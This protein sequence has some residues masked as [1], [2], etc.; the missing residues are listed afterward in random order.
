MRQ[1]GF[2]GIVVGLLAMS[3]V[4]QEAVTIKVGKPAASDRVK[5]TKNEKMN[6]KVNF[7]V[8]GK[9]ETKEDTESKVIVYTDEII[10]ATEGAGKPVKLKRTY[11][12]YE[13]TKGGKDLGGPPLNTVILIEKKDGKFTFT[14]DDKPLDGPFATKLS[15][16][17]DRSA[18]S[19]TVEQLLPGKPVKPGDTWKIDVSKLPGLTGGQA[20]MVIDADTSELT[21]KLVK[22]YQ[23]GGKQYGTLEF[24]GQIGIKSLGEK[25]PLK[26]KA[27]AKMGLKMVADAC[28]DGTDPSGKMTGT[29]S[30]KMEG[31]GGGISL[32]ITADGTIGSSDEL[33][34]KK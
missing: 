21:G 1:F 6:S 28:I 9:A 12:K 11:E 19:P 13:V 18:G 16:E 4:G 3:A 5:V 34:P 23:K 2:A 14:V 31:D 22:T 27:G 29:L 32:S 25:S 8:A 30:I 24:T 7:S 10:T 15:A 26:L 20:G 33:L 17:F